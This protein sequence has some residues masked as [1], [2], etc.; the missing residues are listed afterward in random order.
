MHT[1][2]DRRLDP[3]MSVHRLLLCPVC[4]R[5]GMG[6]VVRYFFFC[7]HSFTFSVQKNTCLSSTLDAHI[8]SC[9]AEVLQHNLLVHDQRPALV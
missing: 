5:V 8:P 2:L 6:S 9:C 4:R 3:T 1:T 7:I